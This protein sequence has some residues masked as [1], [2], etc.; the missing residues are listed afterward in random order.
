MNK[1]D[2]QEQERKR[3]RDA[4]CANA[5]P[6]VRVEILDGKAHVIGMTASGR[7][8]H[9]TFDTIEMARL[10]LKAHNLI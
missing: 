6:I 4:A 3:V 8:F 9:E 1:R 2:Y 7:T 10:W 5:R